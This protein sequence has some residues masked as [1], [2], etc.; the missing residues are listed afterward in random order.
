MQRI[1]MIVFALE[2]LTFKA[3]TVHLSEATNLHSCSA[4]CIAGC[5]GD[6]QGSSCLY[7]RLQHTAITSFPFPTYPPRG[8]LF[9][10]PPCDTAC[11]IIGLEGLQLQAAPFSPLTLYITPSFKALLHFSSF[12]WELN[13]QMLYHPLRIFICLCFQVILVT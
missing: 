10:M 7:S 8:L 9:Y 11:Q 1:K 5:C 12:P 4:P 6:K 2:H 13:Q 3:E